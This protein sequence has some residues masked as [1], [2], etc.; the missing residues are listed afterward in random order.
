MH[1]FSQELYCRLNSRNSE[2]LKELLVNLI[3][4]VKPDYGLMR[5]MGAE[6]LHSDLTSKQTVC[7]LFS[8]KMC[9]RS[10]LL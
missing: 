1:M 6:G 5:M 8:G 9:F 4:T 3:L 2:W 10:W 7:Y